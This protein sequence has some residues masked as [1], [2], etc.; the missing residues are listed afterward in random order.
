MKILFVVEHFPAVSET[1]VLNQ[2]T[3]LLDLGHDVTV[4]SVGRPVA[5]VVHREFAEYRLAERTWKVSGA[6]VSK[7]KRVIR[8]VGKFPALVRR[9]GVRAFAPLNPFRYGFQVFGLGFLYLCFPFLEHRAE[10]DMIQC[11][12]GD[13]GKLA[14]LW[15]RM[16]LLSGPIAT[17]FHAHE[18]AGLD[19]SEGPAVFGDLISSNTLLLPISNRWRDRLIR[20]GADPAITVVH[21]M[22]V[23]LQKF[24]FLPKP[25]HQVS[26]V[27]VLS[28]GRLTEQKGYESAIRTLAHLRATSAKR[29]EYTIV[30]SGEL[31]TS[32]RELVNELKLQDVVVFAGPRTQDEVRR[33]L[34]D[35]DVFFLPSVTA[36]NGFQ[37]GIPVA[38]MEAMACGVPVVSTRH[39]GIPELVEHGVSGCL[40]E[41]HD[42]TKLAEFI[43]RI[44]DDEAFSRTLVK[45]ARARIENGFSM[46]DLN[47]RLEGLFASEISR[48][49]GK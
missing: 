18:L 27:K 23:E 14:L 47:K 35:A 45:N 19:D 38:L 5:D 13:K 46:D 48:V 32:L 10:F 2:V 41:E 1:F 37:E 49:Q 7:W 34:A 30:G 8:A 28:V 29:Y 11:H 31:E 36:R 21:H 9:C 26:P 40:A 6:P 43:E 25:E 20:W 17:V 16:G 42:A 24:P 12:V 4:Y 39:S 44:A 33:Y 22:G 3:G 15:R